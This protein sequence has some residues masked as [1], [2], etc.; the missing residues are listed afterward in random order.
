MPTDLPPNFKGI[1]NDEP[2]DALVDGGSEDYP[3]LI[4]IVG[5][6]LVVGIAAVLVTACAWVVALMLAT[7]PRS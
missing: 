6:A 1:K 2:D 5:W 4:K 7:M 3:L